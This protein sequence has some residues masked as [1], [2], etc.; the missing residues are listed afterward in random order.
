[1]TTDEN[2]LVKMEALIELDSICRFLESDKV[3]ERKVVWRSYSRSF[4]YIIQ[5]DIYIFDLYSY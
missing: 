2:L 1:V 5:S 4:F 3:T